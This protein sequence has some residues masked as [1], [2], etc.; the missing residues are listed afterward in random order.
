M[1]KKKTGYKV[2]SKTIDDLQWDDLIKSYNEL[3]DSITDIGNKLVT[4]AKQIKSET[5]DIELA[6]LIDGV[7]SGIVDIRNK[8]V[9]TAR[10]H[11]KEKDGNFYFF[12]GLVDVNN[13]NHVQ[14]Y[15]NTINVYLAIS[16]TI[17]EEIADKGITA[18]MERYNTVLNK[19]IKPT[20]GVKKDGK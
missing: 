20:E 7:S 14:L 12:S 3:S 2:E 11:G 15:L 16:A 1:S 6:K 9:D 5:D 18:I 4:L 8:I 10:L 13:D 19:N 17:S